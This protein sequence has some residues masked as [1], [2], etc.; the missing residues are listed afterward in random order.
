MDKARTIAAEK[1]R[2]EEEEANMLV[3][4]EL[5]AGVS[6][7]DMGDYGGALLPGEPLLRLSWHAYHVSQ[8]LMCLVMHRACAPAK[9][10]CTL[11]AHTAAFGYHDKQLCLHETVLTLSD[12]CN[13]VGEGAAMH[14]YVQNGKRIPRRGEVGLSADQ[15]SHFEDLGYVMSGSRH[16]RMNAIRIRCG[17]EG[18]CVSCCIVQVLWHC[19]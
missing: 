2:L 15:I 16:S 8:P 4:P 12:V 6:Q 17:S 9:C 18:Q 3:G 1:A 5:P 11:H 13:I 10:T 7:A 19:N 14:A